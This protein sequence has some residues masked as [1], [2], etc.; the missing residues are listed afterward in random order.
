MCVCVWIYCSLDLRVHRKR[1]AG[2][3]AFGA[4]GGGGGLKGEQ[5]RFIG[6]MLGTV[7]CVLMQLKRAGFPAEAP[8]DQQR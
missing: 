8:A 1:V 6:F 3:V 7:F 4:V 5:T 2:R